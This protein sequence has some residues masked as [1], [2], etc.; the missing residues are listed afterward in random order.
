MVCMECV[1]SPHFGQSPLN[2]LL[3]ESVQALACS[4]CLPQASLQLQRERGVRE[5]REGEG[6]VYL[7]HG[8]G[9]LCLC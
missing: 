6:I 9:T 2:G 4:L 5:R 1:C 3:V 8:A 7:V